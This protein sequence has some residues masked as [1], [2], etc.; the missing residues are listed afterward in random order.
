MLPQISS[1]DPVNL[2]RKTLEFDVAPAMDWG[3]NL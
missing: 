2:I 1:S 3:A